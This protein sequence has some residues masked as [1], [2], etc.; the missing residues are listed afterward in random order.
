MS[1]RSNGEGNLRQRP[2]GSW[3][4]RISYVDETTGKRK[5]VSFYGRTKREVRDK[6]KEAVDRIDSG[7]P[8]KDA[9]VTV[10]EWLAH[11]RATTLEASDR[12]PTTKQ[13]YVRLS[14]N[15]LE[16][17]TIAAVRLDRFRASN[18]EGLLVELRSKGLADTSVRLIYTVLRQAFDGAGP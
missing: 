14:Q 11:W 18:V 3:E 15:H 10:A 9:T 12:K 13:M 7:A 16:S 4:A 6:L 17:S 1:K 8:P 2:N 5:R